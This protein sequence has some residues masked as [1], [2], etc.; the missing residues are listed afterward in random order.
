M[1]IALL[2]LLALAALAASAG[3]AQSVDW[4]AREECREDRAEDELR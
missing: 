2:S 1:R 3:A 4:V